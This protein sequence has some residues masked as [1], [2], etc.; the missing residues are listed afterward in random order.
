MNKPSVQKKATHGITV[1]AKREQPILAASK[2]PMPKKPESKSQK[3]AASKKA[4]PAPVKSA[5]PAKP[6]AKPLAKAPVKPAPKAQDVKLKAA[7]P[8]SDKKVAAKQPEPVTKL[9]AKPSE[10]AQSAAP[11]RR[12]RPP[13]SRDDEVGDI[14]KVAPAGAKAAGMELHK[15]I[16]GLVKLAKKAGTIAYKDI[17]AAFPKGAIN[18]D[19]LDDVIH[20]LGDRG[21]ELADAKGAATRKGASA[22][23]DMLGGIDDDGELAGDA[24]IAEGD[25]EDGAPAAAEAET[26]TADS[27]LGK[28]NDPV[29]IYLRKM[30]ASRS[31]LVR[32]KL[33]LRKKLR[34][35]KTG[36]LNVF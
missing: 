23:D 24:E 34:M 15:V 3:P 20:A 13:K 21:I 19:V 32:A 18:P 26:D 8:V 30:E 16:D 22:D 6:T 33:L 10:D 7:A 27:S 4:A 36:S 28:S 9:K 5:T 29:R 17:E 35:K 2:K 11:G 14:A 12:G 31:C 25:A 1:A